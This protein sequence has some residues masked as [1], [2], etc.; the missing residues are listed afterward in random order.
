MR[1]LRHSGDKV[2]RSEYSAIP[3]CTGHFAWRFAP[4]GAKYHRLDQWFDSD[5]PATDCSRRNAPAWTR[6]FRIFATC[7]LP[8]PGMKPTAFALWLRRCR[9]P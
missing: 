3:N 5:Q 8:E 9:K 2:S 6:C 4:G 1:L 7:P